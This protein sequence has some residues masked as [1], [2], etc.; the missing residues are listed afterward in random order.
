LPHSSGIYL[1]QSFVSCICLIDIQPVAV[2]FASGKTTGTAV[3][4]GY[5]VT[6]TSTVLNGQ[7]LESS[8]NQLEIAGTEIT[9]WMAKLFLNKG[10][11][12][13]DR[14]S[15]P[16][17]NT[18]KETFCYVAQNYGFELSIGSTTPMDATTIFSDGNFNGVVFVPILRSIHFIRYRNLPQHSS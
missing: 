5:E 2:L 15:L 9:A 14:I 18:M 1:L 13:D 17:V 11:G 12:F 4:S 8:V 16:Y 7:L 10:F 6:C 3:Q